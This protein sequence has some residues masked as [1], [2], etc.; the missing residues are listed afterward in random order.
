MDE[1]VRVYHGIEEEKTLCEFVLV[2]FS[3]RMFVVL[4]H[5]Y[6]KD[7]ADAGFELMD[8]LCPP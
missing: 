2:W 8:P 7:N 3:G 1:P 6:K 4:A 5:V